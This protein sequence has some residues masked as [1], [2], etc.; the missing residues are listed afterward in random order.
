MEEVIRNVRINKPLPGLYFL[1]F[2]FKNIE[3]YVGQMVELY[4][5]DDENDEVGVIY[6]MQ[7]KNVNSNLC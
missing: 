3:P 5:S 6:L 7:S 1:I 4:S 2:Y